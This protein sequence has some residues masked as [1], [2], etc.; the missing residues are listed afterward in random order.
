MYLFNMLE[1]GRVCPPNVRVNVRAETLTADGLRYS[2]KYSE[3]PEIITR[4]RSKHGSERRTGDRGA[5][6]LFSNARVARVD[7]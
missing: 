5:R 6:A 3:Y 1:P 7:D 2:S 4:Y